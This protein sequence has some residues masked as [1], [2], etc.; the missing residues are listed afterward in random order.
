[1]AE[2]KKTTTSKKT[3]A[4]ASAK[5]T[6]ASARKKK[7]TAKKTTGTT[8]RK[9]KSKSNSILD[10]FLSVDKISKMTGK[11]L[12]KMLP[13][14]L[15][16]VFC[17]ILSVGGAMFVYVKYVHGIELWAFAYGV[18]FRVVHLQYRVFSGPQ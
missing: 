13:L 18:G 1:M 10:E 11:T 16:I 5:S 8:R 3:G 15:G 2:T 9:R 12:K 4:S 7:T 14:L 17:C 6:S